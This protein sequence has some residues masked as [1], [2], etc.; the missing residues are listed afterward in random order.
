MAHFDMSLPDL[1]A[2]TPD[3]REPEDF[4]DFWRTTLDAA[5]AAASHVG[6]DTTITPMP[7][8]LTS[9]A[10][11]DLGFPGFAADPVH[12]WLIAPEGAERP[13][14]VVVEFLGYNGGRGLPHERLAWASAGY[15][16]VVMDTRGQGSP[17]SSG[18]VTSDPHGSGPTVPGY[19]TRGIETP[20]GY[21]FR[22]VFTDAVRCVDAVAEIPWIDA[23]RIVLT[24]TSQGGGITLA[25][26]GILGDRVAGVA[27]DVPFLCHIERAITITDRDPYAE[28]SR[29]LATQRGQLETVLRT[30]SYVDGANHAVRATAPALF[31]VG[32]FDSVCPP[33]TVF[34]AHNRYAGPATIDVFPFN[35]HEGGGSERWPT[36]VAFADRVTDRS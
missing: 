15:A 10:V 13:L 31:S 4:D 3:V 20:E 36:Q 21:Y 23:D 22:R 26:A 27:V 35:G 11:H 25:A 8:R 2:Y 19:L 16:H 32:L 28:I 24:G 33:S 17:F 1:K 6:A 12:A 9:V 34:A 5:R 14:P 18:A 30:L 7:S 29:Y